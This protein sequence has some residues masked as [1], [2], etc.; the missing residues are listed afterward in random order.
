MPFAVNSRSS[1][2]LAS[3]D[4]RRLEDCVINRMVMPTMFLSLM[5]V[6]TSAAS[7]QVLTCSISS[8]GGS[9]LAVPALPGVTT[10]A[11]DLGQTE[12]GASGAQGIADVPGGG[13]VRITCTNAN[14]AGVNP[15]VVIL[16]VSFGVPITNNQTHPST[17]AGIRLINGTGAFITPGPLGPTA[18]NPGNIGIADIDNTA[19]QVVIVLGT[20]GSTVGNEQVPPVIPASG[21][22]FG[23]GTTNTFE[24]AGWLL[25]KAG[26]SNAINATLTA[27]GGIGVVA[28][29]GNCTA[30][31]GSCTQVIANVKP[32]LQDISVPTG[33][34]PSA[35]TSLPNL[36]TTSITGA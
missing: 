16:R 24:L 3:A 30:T 32:G 1:M 12:V 5:F 23:P 2:R 15:G 29:T 13:R 4:L 25:S 21:I 34:L 33:A 26:K 31:A 8:T 35:V 28:G 20:P 19:G 9:I 10:N 6:L 22:T 7:A 14:S 27:T 36:G 18:A 17:A 11:S